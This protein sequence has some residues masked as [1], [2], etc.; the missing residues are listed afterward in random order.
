MRRLRAASKL[1]AFI[2]LTLPLMPVQQAL[3]RFFPG[4][5]CAFPHHY[6]RLLCHLFG[7]RLKVSGSPPP[8]GPKLIVSNHVSWL[9]IVIL[10]AVMPVSFV[11]KKEVSRWPFFGTLARLQRSIFVDRGQRHRAGQ[12]AGTIAA[13]LAAGEAIVLF[14]EGTSHDGTSVLPF[15]TSLFA[16][17]T[18]PD[19]AI[20][21]V[22]LGYVR[23]WGLPLGR[24]KRPAYAWYGDM[25]LVPHLWN[26]LGE[27]PLSVAVIFHEALSEET[28]RDRKASAKA[29][30]T[31]VRRGLLA[32]LH[33]PMDL[34]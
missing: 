24:R 6:H 19:I 27:G 3:L 14:G 22:S 17:A 16:A 9:D 20:V 4:A 30:E 11:A 2:L 12:S 33:G 25:N 1:L 29:A 5:A 21:P 23:A 10:S 26:F 34:R 31:A 13:R 15:K 28:G 7:I 32:A 8:P 18:V